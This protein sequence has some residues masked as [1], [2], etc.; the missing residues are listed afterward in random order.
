MVHVA[1]QQVVADVGGGA[2]HAFDEDFPFGHIKVV[3]HEGARMLGLPEEVFGNISPELWR[4]T[5]ERHDSHEDI[6]QS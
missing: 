3:V 1:V 4:T 2:F 6:L 5:R